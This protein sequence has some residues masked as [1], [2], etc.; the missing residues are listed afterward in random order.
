MFIRNPQS[1]SRT[2]HATRPSSGADTIRPATHGVRTHSSF[3]DL[4]ATGSNDP[5]LYIH[6]QYVPL[7]EDDP[8]REFTVYTDNFSVALTNKNIPNFLRSLKEIQD[9]PISS[10]EAFEAKTKDLLHRDKDFVSG[11]SAHLLNGL[12][13]SDAE[14]SVTV[15]KIGLG[16]FLPETEGEKVYCSHKPS[17]SGLV[18][19]STPGGTLN[20]N[21]DD[22]RTE[23]ENRELDEAV[24]G[25][26]YAP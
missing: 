7:D 24:D 8:I 9:A 5:S 11:F 25:C 6:L 17:K 20:W 26:L 16:D 22:M 19:N 13:A 4:W 18:T 2:T 15:R 14:R 3:Q 23:L 12:Q 21:W 1:R 10:M